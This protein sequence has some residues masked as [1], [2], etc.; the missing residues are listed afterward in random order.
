MVVR[1]SVDWVLIRCR[2]EVWM[3]SRLQ[4]RL[5]RLRRLQAVTPDLRAWELQETYQALAAT[6]EAEGKSEEAHTIIEQ[7]A[8]DP[9]LAG[10]SADAYLAAGQRLLRRG[11]TLGVEVYL[12]KARLSLPE[13]PFWRDEAIEELRMLEVELER[14]LARHKE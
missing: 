8:R 9:L 6:Y 11:Q 14:R 7:Q 4:K 1:G 12:R 2:G 13:D 3:R 5:E 10:R